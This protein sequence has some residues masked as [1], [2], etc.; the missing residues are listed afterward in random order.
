LQQ[1]NTRL[2]SAEE[3]IEIESIIRNRFDDIAASDWATLKI[4]DWID[5]A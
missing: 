4:D 1:S 2:T 3:K 5:C